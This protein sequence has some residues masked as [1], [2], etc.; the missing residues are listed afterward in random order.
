MPLVVM[1]SGN[2]LP[3]PDPEM[4]LLEDAL[5]DLGVQTRVV[6]WADQAGLAEPADLVVIRSTWD[7][8]ND[9]DGFL[10]ALRTIGAPLANPVDV[11]AWNSHK[12]YLVELAAV[13]VPVVPTVL[14]RR[15]A[16][17]EEPLPPGEIIVKPAIA[18]G[19]FGIGRFDAAGPAS[20]AHISV[21]LQTGDVLVQPFQP[22]VMS[23]ERSLMYLGGEFS[24]AVRK[25]PAN[26][27]FRV[28]EF[29]GGRNHQHEPTSAEFSVAHAALA[30][31]P[32]DLLYARVDLVPSADGPLLMELELIEPYLF[33]TDAAGSTQRFAAAIM[34]RLARIGAAQIEGRVAKG[35]IVGP[36]PPDLSAV[37]RRN[38]PFGQPA[39]ARPGRQGRAPQSP[40]HW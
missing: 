37:S 1:L 20:A 24:H 34:N 10:A 36:F 3:V 7:Y 11:V 17:D 4:P 40:P 6:L 8:T 15:G 32:A 28:Q 30:A 35:K 13:G 26:G 21:L 5:A 22:A 25:V 39:G 31:V 14:I 12:G 27:D 38:G 33:L 18:A 9:A 2:N 19:A 23:G 16:P 29:Y